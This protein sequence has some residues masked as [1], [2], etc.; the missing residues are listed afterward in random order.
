L[1]L[2]LSELTRDDG[3]M[4]M[5]YMMLIQV[6]IMGHVF[7]YTLWKKNMDN[8]VV[9]N[10]LVRILTEFHQVEFFG[11]FF[12]EGCNGE[13]GVELIHEETSDK[14]LEKVVDALG[15][16]VNQTT[17]QIL[18]HIYDDGSVEKKFIVE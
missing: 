9:M 7:H 3:E 8:Q 16:E 18:F 11:I 15:R 5:L 14:K 12:I 13:M 4:A 6:G 1:P 2:L 10:G 17:N